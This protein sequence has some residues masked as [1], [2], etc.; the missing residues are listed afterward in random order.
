MKRNKRLLLKAAKRIEEIPQGYNQG[1]FGTKSS[2]APCGTVCCMAGEIV[3][4]SEPTV[5][6]GVQK[7]WSLLGAGKDISEE[8]ADLAG[9]TYDESDALFNT[10]Y[11]WT[12]P[13][14]FQR[15]SP[16]GLKK[17]APK[18]LRYLADGGKV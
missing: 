3:I 10:R 8:A 5:K 17:A 12:W 1:T 18:L 13:E 11:G 4:C 6:K 14:A 7:L 15:R 2:R 16:A 9:L